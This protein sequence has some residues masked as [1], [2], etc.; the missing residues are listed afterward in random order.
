MMNIFGQIGRNLKL[1][2]KIRI[3][4]NTENVTFQDMLMPNFLESFRK[5]NEQIP[6]KVRYGRTGGKD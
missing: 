6:R 5:S 1:L 4:L 2:G 3:F